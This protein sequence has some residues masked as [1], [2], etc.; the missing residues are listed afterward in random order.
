VAITDLAAHQAGDAV[1]LTFTPP[2][3]STLSERLKEVPTLE[4]LRGG[5]KP[6]G[7]VNPKSFRVV[8]TIPGSLVSNYQ[9]KNKVVFEDPVEPADVR[10]DAGMTVVY[11]VRSRVSDKK[12]S[13]SSNDVTVS[14]FPVPERI[15]SV[16]AEVAENGVHLRW[17]A[18]TRTSGGEALTKIDEY[19]VYRGEL[20]PGTAESALKDRASWKAPLTQIGKTQ[21]PEYT[22]ES[23]E[24]GKTYVYLV[25]SAILA[26]GTL[27]ESSDSEIRVVTPKDTFPP[28]A[29]QGLVAAVLPGEGPG[30]A[31]VDLSWSINVE[32]DLAGYR[33]YR[34]E[35][36]GAQGQLLTPELLPT[37]AYRDMSAI[38]GKRYWYTVTAVDRA[39]NES[40]ASSA[41]VAEIPQPSP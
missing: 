37:P 29:P 16:E 34:S 5:L 17:A 36:E 18:P 33:V 28:A 24:F 11:R 20:N 4:I 6:D 31:V 21:Q 40:A 19:R 23:I 10:K 38:V 26:G 7:T 41:V 30:K 15:S 27:L 32:P 12:T 39:G 22:D 14:L 35:A 25:R 1:E 8:D 2:G 9:Q 3:K 13:P